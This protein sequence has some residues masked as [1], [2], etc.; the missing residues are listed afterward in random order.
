MQ[1][2]PAGSAL[3]NK[4]T[5]TRGERK[6]EEKIYCYSG[7][8]PAGCSHRLFSLLEISVEQRI[9]EVGTFS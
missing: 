4:R 6:D 1:Q 2:M 5:D 9:D 7:C 8:I 3:I